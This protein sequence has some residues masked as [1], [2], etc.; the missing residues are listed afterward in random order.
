[1][2]CVGNCNQGRRKC[3]TPALCDQSAFEGFSGAVGL[4]AVYV[5]GVV[6]GIAAV[7]LTL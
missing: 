2:I 3:P 7:L 5:L 1:V 6:T 4:L